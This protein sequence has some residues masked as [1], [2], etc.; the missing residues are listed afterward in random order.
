[1]AG[2]RDLSNVRA[3]Q[4]EEE[5]RRKAEREMYPIYRDAHNRWLGS[6]HDP[7]ATR[8]GGNT[9]ANQISIWN[10]PNL[11]NVMEESMHEKAKIAEMVARD[12]A[13]RQYFANQNTDPYNKRGFGP[14]SLQAGVHF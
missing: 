11:R 6:L 4:E 5:A 10:A 13:R 7:I 3:K 12:N 9:D 2:F 14:I 1:M 8:Q